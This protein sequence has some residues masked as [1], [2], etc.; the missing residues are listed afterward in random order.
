MPK[1]V[2]I[3]DLYQRHPSVPRN[4]KIADIFFKCGF[5][6]SW[7][8]GYFKIKSICQ[9]YKS[10]LPEPAILSGGP[11]V[12]CKASE[13]YR[14]LAAEYKVDGF[15]VIEMTQPDSPRSP[16]QKYRLTKKCKSL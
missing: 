9:E 14:K 10:S 4:P 12:V 5:V 6:E 2:Q 13:T 11:S 15:V 1:T 3:K 8:R 16:T 7:G